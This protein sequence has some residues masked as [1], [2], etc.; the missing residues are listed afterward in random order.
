MPAGKTNPSILIIEDKDSKYSSIVQIVFDVFG[1]STIVDRALNVVDALSAVERDFYDLIVLDI[2]MDIV[3]SGTPGK[4]EGHA[5]LGGMTIVEHMYLL[6]I[7]R[8]TVIVTGFD[9]FVSKGIL[10][11]SGEAQ[12]IHEIEKQAR[13]FLQDNLIGCIKSGDPGWEEKLKVTL[14]ERTQ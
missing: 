9:Y 2:S 11:A 8:P 6:E 4:R 1:G 3:Q 14:S 12:T 10:D 5:V 13:G 7:E